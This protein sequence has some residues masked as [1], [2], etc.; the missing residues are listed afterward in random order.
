MA[1][2]ALGLAAAY[3]IGAVPV[4]VIVA[5][6][7]GGTDPRRLGSGNI[8]ATNVMRALGRGPAGA[9]LAGD[10]VKGA[11]A[12]GVAAA[13]APAP[14]AAAGG[15]VA[16]IAGNCWSVFLRFRGGKGVATGLGAF[17]VLAP[18][19]VLPAAAVFGV[20]IAATR[21]VSLGSIL[22]AAALPIAAALLG[23]PRPSVAAAAAAAAIV[24][25]RHR[26]NLGRLVRGAEPRLGQRTG[27]A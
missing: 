7:L 14:W 23:Y 21:L 3:L 9:T 16:A 24:V 12:V 10:V 22:A 20:A 1:V 19:A 2:T 6:A 5:R 18:W 15:A 8:G 4:G 26:Q 17:L 27:R 11:L 25:V 13:L